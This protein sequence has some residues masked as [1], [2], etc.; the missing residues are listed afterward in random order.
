[1]AIKQHNTDTRC[2]RKRL[3]QH[4]KCGRTRPHRH[5]RGTQNSR[6]DA[7]VCWKLPKSENKSKG[8]ITYRRSIGVASRSITTPVLVESRLLYLS[9]VADDDAAASFCL[10]TDPRCNLSPDWENSS[11]RPGW[12]T[13]DDTGSSAKA[14]SGEKCRNPIAAPSAAAAPPCVLQGVC[15]GKRGG[16]MV[17][18]VCGYSFLCPRLHLI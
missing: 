10:L 16:I 2:Y 12:T 1:M 18:W 15:G 3:D 9:V 5:R 14:S 6:T 11:H 8:R 7:C 13:K 4:R 17:N